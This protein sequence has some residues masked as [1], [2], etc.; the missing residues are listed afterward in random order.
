MPRQL[1]AVAPA[2]GPLRRRAASSGA[3]VLAALV[4][5]VLVFFSG[6][7]SP[8]VAPPKQA[9]FNVGMRVKARQPIL[10][11]NKG[12]GYYNEGAADGVPDHVRNK[13]KEASEE[14]KLRKFV[15]YGEEGTVAGVIHAGNWE[16]RPSHWKGVPRPGVIVSW[17]A[18][19]LPMDVAEESELEMMDST[20]SES[21]IKVRRAAN[22]EKKGL[23]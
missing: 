4:M 7:L 22:L 12:R 10:L 1:I 2:S 9:S 11:S 13:R 21:L 18:K 5:S 3:V 8:C 23:A 17:D 6:R 16:Q 20:V 15:E 19:N 14:R